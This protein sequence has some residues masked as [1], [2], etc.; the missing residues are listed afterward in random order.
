MNVQILQTVA[1]A[2]EKFIILVII[3]SFYMRP[4]RKLQ[5][6][7]PHPHG[8]PHTYIQTNLASWIND[9]KE[10]TKIKIVAVFLQNIDL[11]KIYKFTKS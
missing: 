7:R 10:D 4:P 5:F 1:Q 8:M 11:N 9:A 3:T 2:V 6:L